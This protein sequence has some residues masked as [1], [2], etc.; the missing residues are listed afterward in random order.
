MKKFFKF[1]IMALVVT[2]LGYM[3][4]TI[5]NLIIKFIYFLPPLTFYIVIVLL[6]ITAI[7]ALMFM[8]NDYLEAKYPNKEN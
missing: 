7:A 5:M 6:S 2:S 8:F 3:I 4:A 1:W